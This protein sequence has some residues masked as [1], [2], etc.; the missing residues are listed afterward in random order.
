MDIG[1][2]IRELRIQNDLTLEALASRSE[3]TKGFLSQVERNLTS[4]S[5]ST[6]KDIL[7][8]L[9]TNLSEFF[10]ED[11][12]EQ[13]VFSTQDFFVDEQEGYT[14]EWIVPNAQKNEMEPI[15]LTLHPHKQSHE[16]SSHTGQ[17][18]GY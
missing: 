14:I 1:K 18:F 10:H 11:K 5:I 15:L 4:P 3:L 9:G 6:L 2:K 12:E 17:E 13:I 7:E 8:A 16:L